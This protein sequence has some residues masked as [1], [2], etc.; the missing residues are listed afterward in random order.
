MTSDH[1]K[2]KNERFGSFREHLTQFERD[3]LDARA[4]CAEQERDDALD[5]L[6]DARRHL[7]ITDAALAAS[8]KLAAS[9]FVALDRIGALHEPA[10]DDATGDPDRPPWCVACGHPYPCD[11][12]KAIRQRVSPPLPAAA[13]RVALSYLRRHT[14]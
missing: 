6:R 4:A 14:D 9:M 1:D 12:I 3:Q 2:V 10:R 8:N 7:E 5:D 13:V 11:T